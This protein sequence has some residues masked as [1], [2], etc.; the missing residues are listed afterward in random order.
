LEFYPLAPTGLTALV[1]FGFALLLGIFI[2][3]LAFFNFGAMTGPSEKVLEHRAFVAMTWSPRHF[4]WLIRVDRK[5]LTDKVAR[6]KMDFWF[7]LSL[8]ACSY[9]VLFE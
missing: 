8:F 4:H 6:A 9:C 7:I 5:A 3:S 1:S 2:I